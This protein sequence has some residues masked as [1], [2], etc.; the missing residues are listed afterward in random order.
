MSRVIVTGIGDFA[1][2]CAENEAARSFWILDC[3]FWIDVAGTE[4]R[5]PESQ[6][7]NDRPRE[8]CHTRLANPSPHS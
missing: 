8:I 2:G 7:Q 5:N 6:I 4:I 3:G 1:D